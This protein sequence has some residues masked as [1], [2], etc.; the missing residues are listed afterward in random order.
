MWLT[1]LES[2]TIR[3]TADGQA[4]LCIINGHE[5]TLGGIN[6][7]MDQATGQ[8]KIHFEGHQGSNT[9]DFTETIPTEDLRITRND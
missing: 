5:V 2:F 8:T 9:V 4:N 7:A 3:V 6:L 1:E